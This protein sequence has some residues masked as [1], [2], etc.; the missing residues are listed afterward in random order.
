MWSPDPHTASKAVVI[1]DMGL[2]KKLSTTT[3]RD[4]VYAF[5]Y[6]Q[7]GLMA[8]LGLQGTKITKIK[9]DAEAVSE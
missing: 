7:T 2:G 9:P 5:F 4:G 1:A 3:L 8:G 6:S